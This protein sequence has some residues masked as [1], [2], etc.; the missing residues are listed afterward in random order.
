MFRI[1]L[2][3]GLV[4]PLSVAGQRAK[5][6]KKKEKTLIESGAPNDT[7]RILLITD[8]KDSLFLRRTCKDVNFYKNEGEVRYFA[9]R[10]IATMVHPKNMGVGIAA[11]QVGLRRNI[12]CVQRFDKEGTPNEI[13]V[14]PIIVSCSDSTQM[15]TEGCLSIPKKKGDVKR[16]AHITLEYMDL[17]G[18]KHLEEVEGFTAVIFQHEIDHLRGILFIDHLAEHGLKPQ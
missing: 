16:A 1:L 11:P 10:L 9:K 5:K 8:S 17:D 2:I 3:V 4:L 15:G 14:N 13:F 6:M 12:I 7:L 18:R